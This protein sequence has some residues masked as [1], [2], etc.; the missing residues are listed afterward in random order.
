[1]LLYKNAEKHEFTSEKIL[2]LTL[3]LL[4]W[5]ALA[6]KENESLTLYETNFGLYKSNDIFIN[7]C[8]HVESL[9]E[10]GFSSLLGAF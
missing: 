9:Q 1:M 6:S 3:F 4:H 8:Y 7:A 2:S 10:N 5:C